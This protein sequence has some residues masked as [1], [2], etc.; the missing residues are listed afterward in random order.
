[1]ICIE[2]VAKEN[3]KEHNPNQLQISDHSYRILIISGSRSGETNSLFKLRSHQPDIVFFLLIFVCAKDPFES[4]YQMLIY[5]HVNTGLKHFN[6]SRD[7]I[8]CSN[9][10]YDTYKNIEEY[11][12]NKKRKILIVVGNMIAD[13]LS[14]PILTELEN[15]I[16]LLFLS[17]NHILLYQEILG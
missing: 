3:I 9:D 12:P 13:K 11:N 14:D 4:K 2:D 7:Y 5:K 6:D 1:M 17:H 10:T 8:G 15:L 16:F